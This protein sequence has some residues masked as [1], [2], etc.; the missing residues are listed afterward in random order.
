MKQ[1]IYGIVG[2]AGTYAAIAAR[3]FKPKEQSKLV[4]LIVHEGT[5][6]PIAAKQQ[7]GALSMHARFIERTGSNTTRGSNVYDAGGN[8]GK[9]AREPCWQISV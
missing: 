3:M 9:Q 7:I 6:F 4:G 2:G 5:D 8:R 1:P